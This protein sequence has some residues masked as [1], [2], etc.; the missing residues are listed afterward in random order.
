MAN[1]SNEVVELGAVTTRL[2]GGKAHSLNKLIQLGYAVP[3]GFVVLPQLDLTTGHIRKIFDEYVFDRVAVRSSAINEDGEKTAWAGQLETKLNVGS[4]GLI[5]AIQICRDSG[6]SERAKAYAQ[7]HQQLSGE[8]AV[9][10]QR[11]LH[12]TVSG[13]AFSKHPVTGQDAV[14]IEAVHGLGEPL[15]GGQVTPDTYVVKKPFELSEQ[16]LISTKP[17]LNH[18]KLQ[19]VTALTL[20]IASD[21]AYPVDI[22]WAYEK[23]ILYVLQAR[24]ITTL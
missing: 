6:T 23:N 24:P 22:E 19:E 9:I 4:D 21:F 13:V 5:D 2:I 18:N 14:V 17:I 16:H 8:V 12:S 15:V 11:M 20:S 1:T 10:V 7:V 3:N